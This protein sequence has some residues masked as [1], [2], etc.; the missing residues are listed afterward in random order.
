[1]RPWSETKKAIDYGASCFPHH[2]DAMS[3][4]ETYDEMCL[5]LNV[6]APSKKVEMQ[7]IFFLQFVA[8]CKKMQY[9]ISL[10]LSRTI[11]ISNFLGLF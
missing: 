1:M 10:F 11:P 3:P 8:I 2:K 9:L 7:R 5:Y 6:M 4:N